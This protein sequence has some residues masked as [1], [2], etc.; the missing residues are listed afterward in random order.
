MAPRPPLLALTGGPKNDAVDT[1]LVVAQPQTRSY[2]PWD[3]RLLRQAESQARSGHL[4]LAAELWDDVLGD[5]RVPSV[6][7]TR[8]QALLGLDV[9]F[10]AG[11]GRRKNAALKAIEAQEDWWRIFPEEETTELMLWGHGLGVGLGQLLYRHGEHGEGPLRMFDGRLVP[12]LKVWHPRWLRW[13]SIARQ[14]KLTVCEGAD[15][16]ATTEIVITPGDGTWLLYTPYG[17]QAPWMRGLWRGFSRWWLFKLF[18]TNDWGTHSEKGAQLFVTAAPGSTRESRL[19]LA[20]DLS[21]LASEGVTV[22]PNGFE[23]KLLEVAANTA[24]IYG[25]QIDCANRA[26]AVGA[27]GH[28]LSAE[29]SGPAKTGG[30]NA[31][32]VR[33]DLRRADAQT[34]STCSHD[35]GL[36]PWALLN[37]GSPEHAPWPVYPT[38]PPADGLTEAKR[39]STLSTA[40]AELAANGVDTRALLEG[41]GLPM[42]PPPPAGEGDE[43]AELREYHF[44]YGIVTVNEARS[45]L[46][47]GPLADGDRAP[48]DS[49]KPVPP[50]ADE[51]SG[52][53]GGAAD[54][55]TA[56]PSAGKDDA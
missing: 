24:Q 26:F 4:R 8:I 1:S 35:Q 22:L 3:L 17:R 37:F 10:E 34:W 30:N 49:D 47:F 2:L 46:G 14:W 41:Q 5:D 21:Q 43:A 48:V 31:G 11:A 51:T 18:A 45:R 29:V 27:V 54:T 25:A 16:T 23:P 52:A 9:A 44:K 42:L 56:A 7:R 39:L 40:L 13:D 28:N 33:D 12:R 36:Q 19:E 6:M 32:D 53:A 15:L 38:D 55:H 20:N 50:A